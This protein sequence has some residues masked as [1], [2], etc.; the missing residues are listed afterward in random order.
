MLKPLRIESS[1]D[2]EGTIVIKQLS[3]K[4]FLPKRL[5]RPSSD[6]TGPSKTNE[7]PYSREL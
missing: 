5:E 2:F 1:L 6:S 4:P 7:V 3:K